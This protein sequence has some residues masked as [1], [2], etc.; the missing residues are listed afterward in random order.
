M[1]CKVAILQ[2]KRFFWHDTVDLIVLRRPRWPIPTSL[3]FLFFSS[4][5]LSNMVNSMIRRRQENGAKT[6][7]RSRIHSLVY[8]VVI[9][10][11]R[12]AI[13]TR[14]ITSLFHTPLLIISSMPQ[15]GSIREHINRF[16]PLRTRCRDTI[17]TSQALQKKFFYAWNISKQSACIWLWSWFAY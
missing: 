10:I 3:C 5:G 4:Y 7:K 8:L 12:G 16:K 1:T 11:T 14:S 17:L 6:A 2:R 13:L 9:Q 15:V